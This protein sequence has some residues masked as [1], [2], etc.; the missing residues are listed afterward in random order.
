[1]LISAIY[2]RGVE[3]AFK[4]CANDLLVV[5][6]VFQLSNYQLMNKVKRLQNLRA[7]LLLR[8]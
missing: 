5:S 4:I 1:M 3:D 7:V 6:K 8:E 2:D